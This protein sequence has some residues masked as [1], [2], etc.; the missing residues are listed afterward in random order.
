MGFN[1]NSP[2]LLE[3]DEPIAELERL[4]LAALAGEGRIGIVGGEAGIGKT[5]VLF[6]IRR[7]AAP[8]ILL[9]GIA[10]TGIKG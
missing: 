7:R 3:R 8:D 6:Q 1:G 10:M 4:L 2:E 9:R 5:S